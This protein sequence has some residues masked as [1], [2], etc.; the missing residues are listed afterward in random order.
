M[1]NDDAEMEVLRLAIQ[2][3]NDTNRVAPVP[4]RGR[5]SRAA[6]VTAARQRPLSGAARDK[7]PSVPHD[8][9]ELEVVR[10]ALQDG[11]GKSVK[12]AI[13]TCLLIRAARRRRI[14]AVLT[15]LAGGAALA[16]WWHPLV[17]ALSRLVH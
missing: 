17:S 5:S 13:L 7:P 11:A 16:H 8:D 12:Q 10:L 6:R 3:D 1:A 9:P 4:S 15:S 2:S 14:T